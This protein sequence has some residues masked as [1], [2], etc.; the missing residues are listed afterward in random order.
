MGCYAFAYYFYSKTPV[1]TFSGPCYRQ[2]MRTNVGAPTA[3]SMAVARRIRY[4]VTSFA[5]RI[6]AERAGVLSLTQNAV[7]GQVYR[8]GPMTPGEV[9]D[10]LRSVPQ[11]LTRTFAALEEQGLLRRMPDPDDRRQ[12]LLNITPVGRHAIRAE[13]RPRDAWIAAVLDKELT[14]AERDLLVIASGLLER[15]AAIDAAPARAEP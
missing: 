14:P 12:S 4:G 9:A 10:R 13:M 6:R 8:H 7:L 1:N 11:S 3:E 15:L 2:P 5:V